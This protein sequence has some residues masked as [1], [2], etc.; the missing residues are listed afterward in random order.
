MNRT[1]EEQRAL[2]EAM[3]NSVDEMRTDLGRRAAAVDVMTGC[4]HDS[5]AHGVSFK[6][7][8]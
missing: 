3:A 1:P 8:F 4:E 2:I 7:G 5:H 6:P